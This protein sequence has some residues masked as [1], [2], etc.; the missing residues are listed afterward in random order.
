VV[1]VPIDTSGLGASE[2]DAVDRVAM[3]L[4]SVAHRVGAVGVDPTLALRQAGPAAYLPDGHLSAAGHDAVARAV[5]AAM[6]ARGG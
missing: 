4:A 3:D 6:A 2:A 5:A 1:A